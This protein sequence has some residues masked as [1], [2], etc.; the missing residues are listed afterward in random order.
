MKYADVKIGQQVRYI[1]KPSCTVL[2]TSGKIYTVKGLTAACIQVLMDNGEIGGWLPSRFEL[3]TN[4]SRFGSWY[5]E[6]SN[7]SK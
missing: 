3:M 5:K 6:H 1:D 4:K 7:A 2:L